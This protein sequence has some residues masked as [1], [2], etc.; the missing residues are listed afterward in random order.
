[1]ASSYGEDASKRALESA[2]SALPRLS[3]SHQERLDA[4]VLNHLRACRAYRDADLV[5]V[6]PSQREEADT[7]RATRQALKDGKTVALGAVRPDGSV[8]LVSVDDPT[9]ELAFTR[10]ELARSLCIVPGLVF[11]AEGYRVAY[12]AGYIDNYLA[13][14]EGTTVSLARTVQI[15]SNPLP[16]DGHD[17]P[18][19]VLVSDGAVWMCRR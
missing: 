16:R 18:V 8:A 11:D 3:R 2:Y 5:I 17:V 7:S 14:Y 19:D 12:N 4:D 13:A 10:T 1:M 9:A 6:F 15:S